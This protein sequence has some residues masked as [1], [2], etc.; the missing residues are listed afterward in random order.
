MPYM[1]PEKFPEIF[2]GQVRQALLGGQ[3]GVVEEGLRGEGVVWY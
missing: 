3:R 2:H 1:K